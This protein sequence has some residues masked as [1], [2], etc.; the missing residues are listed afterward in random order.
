[1]TA[2]GAPL[3]LFATTLSG[4]GA[5][6]FTVV[7]TCQ[8]DGGL[9]TLAL[10][11][12]PT[13]GGLR[14]ATVTVADNASDSP[15]IIAVTGVGSAVTPTLTWSTPAPITYGT[16][17]SGTQLNATASVPGTF[18]YTPAVATVLGAG[19]QPLTVTFTPTDTTNYAT[20]SATVLL[21]VSPA[22]PMLTW[23]TPAAI[24]NGTPLSSA[25]LNATA[26]V[27]GTFVYT[28]AAGTVLAA[29]SQVLAV[30][31]TPA[32]TTDY[33]AATATVLLTVAAVQPTTTTLT[34]STNPAQ[35]GQSVSLTATVTGTL[36]PPGP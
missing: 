20:A 29:G 5:G 4:P 36:L 16:A 15:Q 25:Q 24:P 3:A 9:C 30:T 28:P 21:T 34:S 32:D 17:L 13:Q 6:D 27:P 18:V 14:T 31:F 12:T 19:T 10:G 2:A 11:F 33:T 23:P 26:N 1:M 22:T 7:S 35:A 8:G